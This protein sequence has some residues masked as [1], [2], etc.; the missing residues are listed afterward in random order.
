MSYRGRTIE[1]IGDS[2]VGKTTQAGELVKYVYK[3]RGKKSI[4]HTCDRGGFESL[5]PL[6]RAGVMVV[7]EFKEADDPW[8]WI[9]NA[10]AG[11]K[12]TD[13]IGLAVFDSGTSI[14]DLLLSACSHADFQVGQQKTQRF[15]VNRGKESLQVSLNNEAHYGVVQGFLL[16][17]IR[18]STWLIDRGVDVLWTFALLRSE[19]QDRT[20][21]I[22]PKLAGKAM[23]PFLPKE[24]QLTFRL[25]TEVIE[26]Q[27]PEHVLYTT[28]HP[29]L[30]GMGH[31][32][33]NIRCPLGVKPPD[34]IIRPAS[35]IRAIEQLEA[36]QA[37]A[38]ELVRGELG[39]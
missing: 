15:N 14:A 5:N 2:G 6:E 19:T 4:L 16:D 20:P 22:G 18:T 23:T 38:D 32:F 37:E 26:G 30:A 3:T 8:I 33:G 27:A 13:E 35:I 28:M 1:L 17:Q 39:L 11:K 34:P 21:I 31:S 24:F 36:A 12:L 9:N 29:E 10:A 25:D 7:D